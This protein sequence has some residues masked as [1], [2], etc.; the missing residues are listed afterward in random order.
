MNR[1]TRPSERFSWDVPR[2]ND[3]ALRSSALSWECMTENATATLE[4]LVCPDCGARYL[5]REQLPAERRGQKARWFHC[6]R[7]SR[8]VRS[9]YAASPELRAVEFS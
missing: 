7:C 3:G 8:R 1:A 4:Y 9:A 2:A 5:S 6:H